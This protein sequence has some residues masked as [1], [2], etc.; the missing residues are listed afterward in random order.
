[1]SKIKIIDFSTTSQGAW[2]L[3]F[4]RAKKIDADQRFENIIL[5]PDGEEAAL[6]RSGGVDV[7]VLKINRGLGPAD[8]IKEMFSFYRIISKEKPDIIHS[9]N[10]KA[11]A[12]SRLVVPVYNLFN[13]NRICIIH[14]VHGYH[15]TKLKGFKKWI[16]YNIEKILAKFSDYLLFQN[17]YEYSLSGKIRGK[18][19]RLEL[20]GNGINFEE[21]N[22]YSNKDE[23]HEIRI[24]CVARIE[25]VKNHM[26]LIEAAG[27][28]K[29]KISDFKLF[30]IGEGNTDILMNKILELKI[31]ENIVFTGKLPRKEVLSI[32][33]SSDLSVLSSE[34]EGMPRSLIESLYYSVPC[35]AT[36][37]VGTNEIIQNGVSG[38]LV[39]LNNNVE[40]AEKMYLLLSDDK[41]N[42]E[43][44][45]NGNRRCRDNFNEDNVIEKLIN[46]YLKA[47]L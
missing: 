44:G 33:S 20:I 15:F 9:H 31:E 42:K 5:C 2:R 17:E 16:F 12:I 3:L 47:V 1:M 34:K 37:V 18:K 24:T 35:V 46:I 14:Q 13:K 11:G 26:M 25:P 30:I 21:M 19:T 39:P 6:I 45:E 36:D 4:T 8:L 41:L 40:F 7:S 38:F 27:L 22:L 43:M 29:K 28:L 32:L 10:S 23:D